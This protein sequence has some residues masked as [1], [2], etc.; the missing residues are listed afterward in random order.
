MTTKRFT[1][2][3]TDSQIVYWRCLA[4]E[5]GFTIGRGPYSASGSVQK[6]FEA[7]EAGKVEIT[8]KASNGQPK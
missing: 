7:A 5:A 2:D 3:L 8:I 1:L 6:L 4:K